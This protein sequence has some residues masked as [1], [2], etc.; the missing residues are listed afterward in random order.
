MQKERIIMGIDP[1]THVMGYGILQVLDNKPRLMDLGVYSLNRTDDHY[2]RLAKIYAFVIDLIDKYLPDELAIEAPFYGKNVQSLLK[3]G[4]A[5]GV[6]MAAAISRDIPI[7][8][9]APLKIK[10]AI[11]GNGRA[12][13]EQVAYM[14]Q[15]ILHIPV[16]VMPNQLDATDGLA[17]ALCHFYQSGLD[18]GDN[19]YKSWKDFANKNPDKITK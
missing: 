11:T 14:L 8:E 10:V 1:G 16:D 9:Y 12:A 13:K 4:R 15:K 3:L 17:A 18:T 2:M 19:K 7:F 5:Q 6:A